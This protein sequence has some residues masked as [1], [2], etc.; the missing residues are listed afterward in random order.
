MDLNSFFEALSSS[1]P[2]PG[3]GS[4]S[5]VAAAMGVSLMEMVA[6]LSVGRTQE[7][8]LEARLSTLSSELPGIKKRLFDLAEEDARGY[9]AVLEAFRLPKGTEEERNRRSEAIRKAFEGAIASPLALMETIP[10]LLESLIFLLEKGN[11]NA[12]SDAGVAFHLLTVAFEGGKMN[13]LINLD[14]LK[15]AALRNR[16]AERVEALTRAFS[17]KRREIMEKIEAWM[18]PILS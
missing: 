10:P 9:Q 16:V 17:G 15:E 7:A 1:R 11:Q 3:G 4:A 12:F 13:V 18:R 2:V 8:S 6:S 5:C 14:S